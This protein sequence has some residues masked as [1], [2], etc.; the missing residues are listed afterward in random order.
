MKLRLSSLILP[1][2]VTLSA[3]L[4]G[5]GEDGKGADAGTVRIER[6]PAAASGSYV[7][8]PREVAR[9]EYGPPDA[10]YA[11]SYT[12]ES[13]IDEF[14][15]LAYVVLWDHDCSGENNRDLARLHVDRGLAY[16]ELERPEKALAEYDE[17]IGIFPLLTEA[18]ANQAVV[19]ALLGMEAEAE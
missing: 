6:E 9:A 5:C 1:A 13:F 15:L 18:Y 11:F 7:P 4:I 8:G 2:T 10:G 19:R 14:D 17:A 12:A 3:L 16:M